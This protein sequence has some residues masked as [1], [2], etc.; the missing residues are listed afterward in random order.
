MFIADEE[1]IPTLYE[2]PSFI[3][4][5]HWPYYQSKYKIN[6][7]CPSD[8]SDLS[9]P[10]AGIYFEPFADFIEQMTDDQNDMGCRSLVLDV[11]NRLVHEM[12]QTF[13]L[14]AKPQ[15]KVIE[16]LT[17]L[18]LFTLYTCKSS[19][20]GA[21]QSDLCVTYAKNGK[22]FAIANIDL[23]NDLGEGGPSSI[24]QQAGYY[25]H[26]SS[27]IT[28]ALK[29]DLAPMLLVSVVG[30]SYLQAFACYRNE[31]NEPCIDFISEPVSLKY[32]QGDMLN[33]VRRVALFIN[34]MKKLIAALENY[35]QLA[36]LKSQS[37]NFTKVSVRYP[38][39]NCENKL[40][41][42]NR[43][44][45][46]VFYGLL[47]AKDVVIKFVNHRYGF[48]VHKDLASK[49]LAPRIIHHQRLKDNWQVVIM[50][51]VNPQRYGITEL[52]IDEKK[53]NADRILGALNESDYVHGDLRLSNLILEGNAQTIMV[54]DFDWAGV[55]GTVSY[56]DSLNVFQINWPEGV[57]PGG[58]I[59]KSH[60][61][62]L[63]Y[64]ELN[65][66]D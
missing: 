44:R 33:T 34:S 62:K 53:E 19:S 43:I 60:D 13:D 40:I 39:F 25:L 63:L 15:E 9:K 35:Y 49:S 10:H 6:F 24:Y 51:R 29:G 57:H 54:L 22:E 55:E 14:K 5:P 37:R 46:N 59:L 64:E 42:T 66:T 38:Y 4:M 47:N 21:I 17:P 23:T 52:S 18:H 26:F 8:H 48:C 56:P 3:S 28:R 7:H 1:D 31:R 2:T 20:K 61:K 30:H 58:T 36:F 16:I 11:A 50:E 65:I 32:E 41:Y 45:R 12:S 27:E